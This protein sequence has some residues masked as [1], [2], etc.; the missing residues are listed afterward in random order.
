MNGT[1]AFIV[2]VIVL[3]LVGG[4]IFF[5]MGNIGLFSPTATSTTPGSTDTTGQTPTPGAP[6]AVTSTTVSPFE[7]GAVVSGSVSP[8]GAFTSYWYEYGTSGSLGSKTPNQPIGSGF[9]AITAPAYITGLSKNTTY[10]FRLVAENQFGVA[11]GSQGTFQ[12][13]VGTPPVG[14]V[15]TAQTLAATGVSRTAANLSGSV[16]PNKSSTQFWFEYGVSANLGNV[17][18]LQSVGDGALAVPASFSLSNLAPATTY[19]YRMNAQ[20]QFGTVTGAIMTFTTTGP[21]A[22][23]APVV[24]TLPAGP[25]ATTTATLRGTAHPQ[26]AQTMY[27][28]EYSTDKLFGS[29][30]VRT[31]PQRSAGAGGTTVSVE[32]N[33]SGLT[34]KTTYYYRTVAQNAADTARATSETFITK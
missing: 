1:I 11:A 25:V 12:T 5:G 29:G 4:L 24:T 6:I 33:V 16:M 17:T 23:A 10:Y 13:T 34:S 21:A 20:N 19:Y 7:T 3:I 30:S 2:G 27:W 32:A 31:T 26:S 15:P 14:G 8:H 9:S 18:T 22:S 28:F